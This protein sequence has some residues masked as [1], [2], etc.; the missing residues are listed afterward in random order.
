MRGRSQPNRFARGRARAFSLLELLIT[1]ALILILF[2]MLYGFSSRSHQQ[3]QKTVCQKNLTTIYVALE[4]F[5]KEHEGVF[6][7]QTNAATSEDA[8]AQLVPKYTATTEMFICPGSK[9][10]A[11]PDGESLEKRRISYAYYMGERLESSAELLM[12]DQQIDTR[13]KIKGHPAFSTNGKKP[14]NNHHKFG[15]NLLYCDG[16]TEMIP[17]IAPF[18]LIAT[19][20]V[21]LLNPRPQ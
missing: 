16:R 18:S 1:M 10:K 19:Q 12:S 9:D 21:V 13:P 5:A 15:G 8:L 20:G 14:G 4:I 3:Q 17:A 11:I 6:P 7:T 2:V